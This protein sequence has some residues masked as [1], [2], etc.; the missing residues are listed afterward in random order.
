MK[1]IK[2]L[3]PGMIIRYRTVSWVVLGNFPNSFR[4]YFICYLYEARPLSKEGPFGAVIGTSSTFEA[5]D[6]YDSSDMSVSFR[7]VVKLYG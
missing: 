7:P 4:E 2:Q 6:F 1:S 3:R 5:D